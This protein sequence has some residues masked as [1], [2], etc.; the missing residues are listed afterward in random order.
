MRIALQNLDA[1]R[2]FGRLLGAKLEAG[3]TLALS[4]DLGAGKTTLTQAIAEGMGIEAEVSSP[5][6]ALIHEYPGRISLFHADP[7]RLENAADA[8]SFGFEEYFERSGVVVVEWAERVAALLPDER[9]D[10]TLEIAP[11]PVSLNVSLP[12]PAAAD[13]PDTGLTEAP[14]LLT[15]QAMGERYQRLLGELAPSGGNV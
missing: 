1:T 14:R 12:D 15:L 6:Y 8:L 11:P 4:G 13:V 5:T 2:A 7:Y 3:D 10:L 9:L